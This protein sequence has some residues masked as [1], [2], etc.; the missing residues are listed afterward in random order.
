MLTSNK[1]AD[2]EG[3]SSSKKTKSGGRYCVA[4]APNDTPCQNTSYSAGIKMYQ[5]PSDEK[6][7]QKRTKFVQRHRPYFKCPP[8]G[9]SVA[10]CSAHFLPSCFTQ[11]VV[12]VEGMNVNKRLIRGS[13]PT[14]AV[15]VQEKEESEREKRK[16][17]ILVL[18]TTK[19][20]SF[21]GVVFKRFF[22][23]HRI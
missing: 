2:S 12:Y 5:F 14:D 1:M 10:L 23:N 16:V 21:P 22:Q 7:R 6:L 9:K 11:P 3:N 13:V 8:K 20:S 17:R 15:E 19:L 4:G 18:F